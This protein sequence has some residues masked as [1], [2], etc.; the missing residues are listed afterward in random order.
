[1]IFFAGQGESCVKDLSSYATGLFYFSTG[2]REHKRLNSVHGIM[3]K[4][5]DERLWF[6]Q[7]VVQR[8]KNDERNGNKRQ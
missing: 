7:I 8:S 6:P 1:M 2:Q 3:K 4:V 5:A